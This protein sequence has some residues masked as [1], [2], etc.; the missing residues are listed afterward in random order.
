MD[1]HSRNTYAERMNSET[2]F[3]DISDSKKMWKNYAS[4]GKDVGIASFDSTRRQL[5]KKK[6]EKKRRGVG[7]VSSVSVH[8]NRHFDYSLFVLQTAHPP[9]VPSTASCEKGEKKNEHYVCF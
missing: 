2:V 6:R 8:K 1:E 7:T 9:R 4:T 3:S 5:R